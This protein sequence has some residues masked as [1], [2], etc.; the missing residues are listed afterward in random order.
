[1]CECILDPETETPTYNVCFI[2]YGMTETGI[3]LE[4]IRESKPE[5]NCFPGQAVHCALQEIAPM[6]D[7]WV[8]ETIDK[9]KEITRW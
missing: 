7:E 8:E 4:S 2:D 6:N 5:F 9:F 3:P 1:M